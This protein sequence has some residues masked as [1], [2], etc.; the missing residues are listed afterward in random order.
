MAYYTVQPREGKAGMRYRCLV[1]FSA[2]NGKEK[3]KSKTF[4]KKAE[5]VAWGKREVADIEKNGTSDVPHG[6]KLFDLLHKYLNDPHVKVGRSKRY[7]LELISDCSIAN[8]TIDRLAAKHIT[9]FAKDRNSA[10]AK[11]QTVAADISNLRSVLRSA[12]ALYGVSIDETCVREAMGT[13]QTLKLVGKAERRSRRPLSDELE[14]LKEGLQ[15]R[16]EK[17]PQKTPFI[18]ILDFSILSCMRIGEVCSILW[19]DL[20]KTDKSVLVRDRKDPR[21]KVGNHMKVPLIGGAYEIILRQPV[22]D[23]PRIFP[24]NDR[25]ITAG[26]QRVRNKLGIEDLRYHDLR[27][28]GASRLFEKGYSIDEVAQVTGHRNLN[29]LWQIYTDLNPSRLTEKD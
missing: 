7:S 27:R 16:E 1:R 3:S 26:F 29:T 20:D 14:R 15:E 19:D 24:F 28:E 18:D 25:T 5:A 11:P 21:K 23:D 9:E 12:K 6:A 8:I 17:S 2:D 22:T 4:G 13:L 10:G